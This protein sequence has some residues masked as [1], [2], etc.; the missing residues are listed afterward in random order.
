MRFQQ[1]RS[2]N[3]GAN[4]FGKEASTG[5]WEHPNSDLNVPLRPLSIGDD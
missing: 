1:L 2:A 4:G 5:N 3:N